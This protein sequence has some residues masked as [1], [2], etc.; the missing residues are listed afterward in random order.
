MEYRIGEFSRISCL[1][2]KTL[3]FYHEQGLL[4]PSSIDQKT[5][6]RF[7]ND[8]ACER[9]RLIQELR[10]LEF[11][12]KEIRGILQECAEDQDL[13]DHLAAKQRDIESR[14]RHYGEIRRRLRLLQ[15]SETT[16]GQAN[17]GEAPQPLKVPELLVAA[18][19]FRGRYHEIGDYLGLLYH[20]C[21][22]HIA[23]K[24]FMLYYEAEYKEDDA[25]LELCLPVKRQVESDQVQCRLLPA[26]DMITLLH[27]GPYDMLYRSYKKMTDYFKG[28]GWELGI[29]IREHYLK[30]PGML[31][32]GNPKRY[33]TQIQVPCPA[34]HSSAG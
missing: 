30:G 2:I 13:L 1:S 19:R 24:P 4:I 27:R 5:G 21:S 12:V 26:R 7:Y 29:P 3:R 9:A 15:R 20:S 6:Y 32:R 14:I 17:A 25:D 16:T 8:A 22:R 18:I 23:G 33:L 34:E 11:S 10:A 28:R 31:L